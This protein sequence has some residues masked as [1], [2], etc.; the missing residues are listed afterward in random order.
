VTL[1]CGKMTI[2]VLKDK[3]SFTE[4]PEPNHAETKEYA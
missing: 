1:Q 2:P 3:G 4:A